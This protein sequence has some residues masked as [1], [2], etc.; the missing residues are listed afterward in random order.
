MWN[1]LNIT[2]FEFKQNVSF[3][4]YF[5]LHAM[6]DKVISVDIHSYNFKAGKYLLAWAENIPLQY[7]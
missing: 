1:V 4:Q 7:F 2:T 3:I 6:F 5:L